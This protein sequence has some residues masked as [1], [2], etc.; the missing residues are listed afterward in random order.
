MDYHIWL[1][2]QR[3]KGKKKE[4]RWHTCGARSANAVR[5]TFVNSKIRKT[6]V[7]VFANI[8]SSN[9]IS[10]ISYSQINGYLF[11]LAR[12]FNYLDCLKRNE[13][14][15]GLSESV[16]YFGQTICPRENLKKES[17]NSDLKLS[18]DL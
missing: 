18:E 13:I 11:A 7:A 16:F 5:S 14:I 4:T 10:F 12:C 17:S 15:R 9:Q 1:V 6:D 2:N 8:C 3:Q